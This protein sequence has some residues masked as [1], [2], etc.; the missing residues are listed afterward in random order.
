MSPARALPSRGN[1]ARRGRAGPLYV[2]RAVAGFGL[3]P[4]LHARAAEGW[5]RWLHPRQLATA[6][7]LVPDILAGLPSLEDVPPPPTWTVRWAYW[8]ESNVALLGVGSAGRAQAVIKLPHTREGVAALGAQTRVLTALRSHPGLESWS[9]LLPAVMAEG[10]IGGQPYVVEWALPGRS[11]PPR[12]S[13][14]ALAAALACIRFLHDET[15]QPLLVGPDVLER[16]VERPAHRLR[17]AMPWL[18]APLDRLAKALRATLDG[19]TVRVGWIHGDFWSS[20]LLTAPD[21][22]TISGLVDWDLAEPAELAT[23][24]ALNVVLSA[25]PRARGAELGDVIRSRLRASGWLRAE[26]QLLEAADV[27]LWGDRRDEQA[28]V[29]LY[30]LRFVNRYLAKCPERARDGWWLARNVEAVLEVV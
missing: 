27:P 18:E 13:Q 1:P 25:A 17:Q 24:D 10:I 28:A 23:H 5:R 9:H 11:M 3:S 21:G 26:R 15:S 20:N 7:R 14:R 12:P 2:A 6:R 8:S 4:R 22:E 19:R 30:W 16:W 29:Y